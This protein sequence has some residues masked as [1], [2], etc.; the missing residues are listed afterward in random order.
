MSHSVTMDLEGFSNME[1]LK[2]AFVELGWKI[3]ENSTSRTYYNDPAKDTIYPVVAVNP[4]TAYDI[5]L[6]MQGDKVE[7]VS[8]ETMGKHS[9]QKTLGESYG[10]LKM[11]YNQQQY[12]VYAHQRR[13]TV[14]FTRLPN[15]ATR[16]EMEVE[17]DV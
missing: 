3:Q 2:K 1:S 7:M 15:G 10:L 8:D 9:F 6:R 4:D 16:M 14:N 5:G 13:G 11:A 12:M 17:V